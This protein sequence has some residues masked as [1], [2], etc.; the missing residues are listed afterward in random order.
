MAGFIGQNDWDVKREL[1]QLQREMDEL[2]K[3]SYRPAGRRGARV[4]PSI[5]ISATDA[6]LLVRAEVPGMKLEDFEI[7]VSGDMLTVQGTR[8]TGEGLEGGWYHRRERESG[9]FSRAV[10]LPAE[11]DGDRAEA[12]YVAGVLTIALPLQQAAKP[13]AIPVKVLEG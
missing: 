4:F 1:A 2:S 6:A 5:I 8:V 12:M 10:R 3:Q 11:V 7:T 9:G 13:K